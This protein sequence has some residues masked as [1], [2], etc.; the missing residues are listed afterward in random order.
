MYATS[1]F[2]TPACANTAAKACDLFSWPWTT[3]QQVDAE[4]V[5]RV[6]TLLLFTVF[7]DP[8]RAVRQHTVTIYCG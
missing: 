1:A 5:A 8:E 7:K 6:K 3:K 2:V 4:S